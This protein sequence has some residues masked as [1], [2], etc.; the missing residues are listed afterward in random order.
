VSPPSQSVIGGPEVRKGKG[1]MNH[2]RIRAK[3]AEARHASVELRD[4]AARVQAASAQIQQRNGALRILIVED[5]FDSAE[6]LKKLLVHAGH[7]A[8]V[9]RTVRE[10]LRLCRASRFSRLLCDIGLPDGS[11]LDLVRTVKRECPDIRAIALSGYAM[12]R[13]VQ[14]AMQAGFDAHLRKPVTTEQLLT[15]LV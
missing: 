14:A 4:R 7:D 5:H 9:A 15:S 6:V 8:V 12:E 1:A 11:G 13:D 10:A 3:A 2:D